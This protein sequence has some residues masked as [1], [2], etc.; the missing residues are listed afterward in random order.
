MG[1]ILLI[2]YHFSDERARRLA[3]LVAGVFYMINP[4]IVKR[5][6]QGAWPHI[7]GMS[8]FPFVFAFLIK[9]MAHHEWKKVRYGLLA[10]MSTLFWLPMH[11]EL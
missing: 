6:Y 3:G 2:E 5:M 7:I 11:P 9:A 10:S 1:I 8:A 4:V